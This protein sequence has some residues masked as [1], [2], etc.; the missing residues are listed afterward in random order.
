MDV[1]KTLPHSYSKTTVT[2]LPHTWWMLSRLY[3]IPTQRLNEI[4]NAYIYPEFTFVIYLYN[5]TTSND[6]EVLSHNFVLSAPRLSWI[7]THNVSGEQTY[8]LLNSFYPLH[9]MFIHKLKREKKK[10]HR[11]LK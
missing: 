6:I 4:N 8:N 10:L 5:N 3:H 2:M 11:H 7:R 9:K 1:I